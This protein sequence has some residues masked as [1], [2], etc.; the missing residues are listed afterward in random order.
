MNVSQIVSILGNSLVA[1]NYAA[2]PNIRYIS[3]KKDKNVLVPV[4][5]QR[6]LN[7]NTAR[8]VLEVVI[9]RKYST[10]TGA[11]PSSDKFPPHDN[12]D[13]FNGTVYEY[14]TDKFGNLVV[15]YYPFDAITMITIQEV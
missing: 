1:N 15:D 5:D 9:C 4:V 11:S 14:L 10:Y 13:Y 7:F 2:Y 8:D 3:L 12:Y 6:R